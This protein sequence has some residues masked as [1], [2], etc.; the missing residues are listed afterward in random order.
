[1]DWDRSHL[2]GLVALLAAGA[3]TPATATTLT[4]ANIFSQFNAVV[5]GNF[6]STADVEGRT[7]IGGNMTGGSTFFMNPRSTTASSFSS[8]S[9]YGNVTSGGNVNIN[10]GGGFAVAGTNNASFNLNGGGQAYIGGSNSGTIGSTGSSAVTVG[11]S[12][13]G[14]LNL[15][16]GGSVYIGAGN[17]GGV[18]A[19]ASLAVQINGSNNA[20]LNLNAGGSVALNGSNSGTISMNGGSV[21]YTGSQGNMN[22]NGG[23]TATRVSSLNLTA[24]AS[25]LGSFATTFQTPLTSLSTQLSG[26]TANS[27]VTTSGNQITFNAD[28]DSTG[29][30]V[31]NINASVFQANDTVTMNLDGATSVIINVNVAGCSGS[32]CALTMPANMNFNSPTS[33]ADAVLWNFANATSLSFPTEFGGS[34]LAPLAS[35]TNS[36]PIDGTLVANSYSGNGELHSYNYTGTLPNGQSAVVTNNASSTPVPEPASLT[37]LAVGAAGLVASRRRRTR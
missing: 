17:S 26:L 7:V 13:S 8:I 9:V 28:P 29:T 24:P 37:L 1:M 12:N 16:N 4:D 35:V 5:F 32:A 3:A 10:S 2:A 25:T 19:G 21:T 22:L 11:G 14:T 20:N 30:A 15:N 27:S 33:Y 36:A 34:I 18:G 6:T 31:F 23:A